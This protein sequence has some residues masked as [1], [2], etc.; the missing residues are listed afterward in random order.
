MLMQI[1]LILAM[2]FAAPT[3]DRTLE[4]RAREIDGN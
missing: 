3:Q 2:A 4:E 1:G